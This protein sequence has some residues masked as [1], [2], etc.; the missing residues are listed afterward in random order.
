MPPLSRPTR[1]VTRQINRAREFSIPLQMLIGSI[2]FAGASQK[3]DTH[4]S[5]D[6]SEW[7][8]NCFK[9]LGVVGTTPHQFILNTRLQRAAVR[10]RRT[11]DS[12]SA[13]A[14]ET[15]FT[16][17]STFNRRCRRMIRSRPSAYRAGS[18]IVHGHP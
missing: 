5:C 14:F 10:L 12:I 2:A 13:I 17:L 18:G 16:D 15:G 8:R 7:P 11:T 1:I 6:E 4:G 9:R 3:L